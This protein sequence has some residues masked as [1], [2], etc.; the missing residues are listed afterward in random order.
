MGWLPVQG[1]A[2]WEVAYRGVPAA[3]TV[4]VVFRLDVEEVAWA[5]MTLPSTI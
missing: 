5:L 4:S 3:A 1:T 2:T